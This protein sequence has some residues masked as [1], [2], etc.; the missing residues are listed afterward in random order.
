MG[1]SRPENKH[2]NAMA[3]PIGIGVIAA[4]TTMFIP[5]SILE[6]MTGSTGLSE[7]F[8]STGAPL[9]DTAR[10]LI[11]FGTGA[12]TLAAA[13]LAHN[14]KGK[15]DMAS[16]AIRREA[17]RVNPGQEHIQEP[18]VDTSL[19]SKLRS[20]LEYIGRNGVP[21]PWNKKPDADNIFDL[22]DLPKLRK[23]DAHP[24]AP[25]RRPLSVD[26]D[27][28]TEANKSDMVANAPITDD[29]DIPLWDEA[30]GPL[31]G[32][33]NLSPIGV[34]PVA[35]KS[36]EPDAELTQSRSEFV[37]EALPTENAGPQVHVEETMQFTAQNTEVTSAATRPVAVPTNPS[38]T[39]AI[40][41]LFAKLEVSVQR[42]LALIDQVRTE[43]KAVGVTSKPPQ[44]Q[45]TAPGM[46]THPVNDIL[47]PLMVQPLTPVT[48]VN[49]PAK[50]PIAGVQMD[51]APMDEAPMDEALRAA[52]ATLQKMNAQ[53]R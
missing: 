14:R 12:L 38:E 6:A 27:V 40:E 42:R 11:A 22:K 50:T 34:A 25:A 26:S 23:S 44:F 46:N 48:I 2:L 39:D 1:M 4:V 41:D 30:A 9:G 35:T 7:I 19:I 36:A 49:A 31:S 16:S 45:N 53:A 20:K 43:A 15:S 33:S 18:A 24:D 13:A 37:S 3:L 17:K 5:T 32:H 28:L 51:E 10:A 52:L 29:F 21:L 47:P 8:P